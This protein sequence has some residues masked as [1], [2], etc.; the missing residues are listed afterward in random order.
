MYCFF[1]VP[2]VVN[3][4]IAKFFIVR[5]L[6]EN[7]EGPSKT[8]SWI[9]MVV[10]FILTSVR[11]RAPLQRKFSF[12]RVIFFL[13]A[14]RCG[15]GCALFPAKFLHFKLRSINTSFGIYLLDYFDLQL[16]VSGRYRLMNLGFF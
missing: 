12:L 2:A 11:Q 5:G 3:A 8:F 13:A 6:F 16:L 9:A 10:S 1:T 14:Y 15:F 7:R 4:I